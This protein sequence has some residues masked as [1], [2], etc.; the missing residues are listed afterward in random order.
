MR[1]GVKDMWLAKKY[2]LLFGCEMAM[3]RKMFIINIL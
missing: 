2:S 3:D 1:G